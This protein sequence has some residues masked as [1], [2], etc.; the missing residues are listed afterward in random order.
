M[1]SEENKMIH[2]LRNPWGWSE[3]EVRAARLWAADRLDPTGRH[4]E[5]K[6]DMR[7]KLVGD[8]CSVCNIPKYQE[9]IKEDENE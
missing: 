1:T 6:C 8:G 3:D 4:S 2:I 5:C 9:M 7:T